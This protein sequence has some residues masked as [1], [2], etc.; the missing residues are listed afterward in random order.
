MRY[1]SGADQSAVRISSFRAFVRQCGRMGRRTV[2]KEK[3]RPEQTERE[4]QMKTSRRFLIA[5]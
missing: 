1:Y 2:L 3:N 5:Q 4:F